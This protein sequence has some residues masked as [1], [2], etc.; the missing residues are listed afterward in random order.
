[1]RA[2]LALT[3]HPHGKRAARAIRLLHEAA[4]HEQLAADVAHLLDAF[5]EVCKARAAEAEADALL[6]PTSPT[7]RLLHS[8]GEAVELD[9]GPDGH[10]PR[11]T[12]RS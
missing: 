2:T 12:R 6:A 1:M 8:A 5:A 11:R 7:G 4:R 3:R 9:A 10:T